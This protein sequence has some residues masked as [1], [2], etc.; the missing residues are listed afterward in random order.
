MLFCFVAT[1]LSGKGL[2]SVN[3]DKEYECKLFP[4]YPELSSD[5]IHIQLRSEVSNHEFAPSVAWV[6]AV[7]RTG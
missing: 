5:D 3:E 1:L 2:I 4:F 6:E 7:S